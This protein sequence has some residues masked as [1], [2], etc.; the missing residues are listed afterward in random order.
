MSVQTLGSDRTGGDRE[1]DK[2][3]GML[4]DWTMS[5]PREEYKV[6]ASAVDNK[7]ISLATAYPG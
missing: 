1:E 3:E 4:P 7:D 2:A 5:E 6:R